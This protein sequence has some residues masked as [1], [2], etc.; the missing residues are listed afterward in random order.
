MAA[1]LANNLKLN[2]L[3]K[4][5]ADACLAEL[6]KFNDDD[7]W[8]YEVVPYQKHFAIKVTDDEGVELGL[9]Y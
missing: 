1:L 6:M 5:S 3:T 9:L 4:E 2:L 7:S 8:T